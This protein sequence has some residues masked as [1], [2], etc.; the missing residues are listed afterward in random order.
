MTFCKEIPQDKY[1]ATW[2]ILSNSDLLNSFLADIEKD[3]NIAGFRCRF[4][5]FGQEL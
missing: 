1:L 4:N 2:Y 5:A 3:T